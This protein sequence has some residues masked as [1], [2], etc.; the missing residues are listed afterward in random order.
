MLRI[1]TNNHL[2]KPSLRASIDLPNTLSL[3]KLKSLIAIASTVVDQLIVSR[4]AAEV[5]KW[6][7]SLARDVV[8]HIPRLRR[9]QQRHVG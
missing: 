6:L 4:Y 9:W 8:A 5:E 7:P 2:E 1:P 3:T